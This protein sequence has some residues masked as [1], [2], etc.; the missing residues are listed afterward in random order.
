MTALE[1][2]YRAV[3]LMLTRIQRRTTK[4]LSPTQR[5]ATQIPL[6]NG[7]AGLS[8]NDYTTTEK[9]KLAGITPGADVTPGPTHL[10]SGDNVSELINDT[11]YIT[12][13]MFQSRASTGLTTRHRTEITG[14]GGLSVAGGITSEFGTSS[15]QLG[16]IAPLNDWSVYPARA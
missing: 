11:G 10:Q 12:W 8:L 9:D 14:G 7:T 3:R 2:R 13:L 1:T 5:V 15:A 4:A 6:G 16:N